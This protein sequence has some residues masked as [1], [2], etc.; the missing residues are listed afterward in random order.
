MGRNVSK[1][2]TLNQGHNSTVFLSGNI[3]PPTRAD[4]L[5]REMLVIDSDVL[6]SDTTVSLSQPIT[7]IIRAGSWI[8]FETS[9]EAYFLI[10]VNVTAEVGDTELS[11]SPVVQ[12]IPANVTGYFPPE[13]YGLTDAQINRTSD[14]ETTQNFNTGGSAVTVSSSLSYEVTTP[15]SIVNGNAGYL[16][17]REAFKNRQPVWICILKEPPDADA[18][19]LG[20]EHFIGKASIT[21]ASDTSPADG[22]REGGLSFS[23]SGL[24]DEEIY[25]AK[26]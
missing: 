2:L 11:V 18:D 23:I 15:G 24:P 20:P 9:D 6:K 22:F 17:A 10:R 13:I 7:T 25:V 8:R 12:D 19:V 14:V 16:M 1:T 4:I 3:L 26:D 21:E 5:N